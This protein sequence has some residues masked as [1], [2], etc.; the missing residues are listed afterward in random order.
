MESI[1]LLVYLASFFV[2]WFGAGLIVASVDKI[3]RRLRLSSFAFSF[4]VL[5]LLTSIPEFAVGMTALAENKAEVFVGNLI[6][7]VPVLFLFIMPLLAILGKGIKLENN[8]SAKNLLL[9]FVVMLIPGLLVMDRRVTNFE[10][11]VMIVMYLLLFFQVQREKGIF[12]TEHSN[13]LKLK[14][15]SYTDILKVLLGVGIVF[16]AGHTVV[17]KTLYF[18]NMFHVSP[19]YISL[20][21]LSLGT[22]LPELSL[23]IRAV[24]SGKKDVAFGDYVGS[25]AANTLLFGVFTLVHSGEVVTINNFFKTFLIMTVSLGVFFLFFSHQT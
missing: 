17:D 16:L 1:N 2:L 15:Y 8:L 6:G 12:D 4:F 22:N 25:A 23:A 24:I 13:V 14:S 10:A 3:S 5:G 19:F 7:G 21:F 20:V 9:S 18:A 11:V